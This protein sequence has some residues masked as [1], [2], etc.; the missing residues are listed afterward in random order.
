LTISSQ[1]RIAIVGAALLALFLAAMDALVMS[2]A[3][4][5]IVS[6]LGGLHLYSWVYSSYFLARAV[7]LPVFGKLA[8]LYRNR[9]LFMVAIGLFILS[10]VAAGFALNMIA[11]IVA[12]VFQGIAAGGIFAL[13]Y[14]VLADVSLPGNRGRTLSFASSI[15]GVASV[16]GPTLGGFIVT[17][18]SWRW[19]FFINIPLG[20]VSLWGIWAYLSE[21]RDKRE[22]VSLDFG[23]V[24]TLSTAILA[25][26]FAFLLG[27]RTYAWTSPFIISLLLLSLLSIAA[28]I[29]VEN[30][31]KDP[32]LSITF[33]RLRGFSAGNGAVFF[34]SFSIFSLFAFAPLFIQGAQGR[35]PMEVGIAMLSLSLGWSLGAL[36]LGQGIDRMGC[37]TT[38]IIGSL[39][40]IGGCGGTLG[41]TPV[42]ST[43][44]MFIVFFVLGIG[45][46][47]VA[48]S[49]LLV[50]QSCVGEKDLGVATASNQF[51][52][53]LGGT[54]G[55]GV[56]GSFIAGQFSRLFEVV[57]DTGV[58]DRLPQRLNEAG[59]NQVESLLH[60]EVQAVLPEAVRSMLQVAVVRGVTGIFWAATISAGLCL[61]LC[62]FI[63]QEKQ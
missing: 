42:T 51:A 43:L 2:A 13:V 35:S 7:S 29:F 25:F 54:V 48:L 26:L 55:V 30:R 39:F 37:R 9:N 34:S 32:I 33:F 15:W 23:G 63:P 40:L 5:T 46:G 4:P 60:P 50:V 14:I 24:A 31:A 52:R 18:F 59:F 19:I 11:L 6:E 38:A 12:R 44:T 61:L 36:A 62:L 53:T 57:Q 22:S 58:M 20:L 49:T 17:Y 16:L 27:G 21:I 10:S 3:M 45:M 47:W 56:C 28:F 1:Q 8:D 41:F